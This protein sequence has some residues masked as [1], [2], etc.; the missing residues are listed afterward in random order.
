MTYLSRD[1]A[2]IIGVAALQDLHRHGFVVVR[3]GAI[4]E[5]QREAVRQ[6]VEDND[7]KAVRKAA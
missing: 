7:Y 1:A 5:A 6:Y 4:G 3:K 2:K